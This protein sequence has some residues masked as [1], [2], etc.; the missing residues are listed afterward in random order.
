MALQPSTTYP[1]QVEVGA[2]GYP[3]GKAQDELVAGDGT[4]TPLERDLVNDI[5]G[6]QQALLVAGNVFPSGT[7]DA[8]GASDYLT[9]LQTLF[10][11]ADLKTQRIL[12]AQ[13]WPER[14]AVTSIAAA[15]NGNKPMAFL[16]AGSVK[17]L[18]AF[19]ENGPSTHAYTSNDG[20]MWTQRANLALA[21]G[22]SCV[23]AGV[24][25]GNPGLLA[26]EDLAPN[27]WKSLD[28]A[29]WTSLAFPIATNPGALMYSTRLGLWVVASG[30]GGGAIYTSP[31]TVSWTTQTLP[32]GW[33]GKVAN[34]I[35]DTGTRLIVSTSTNYDK[36]LT[37]PDG[38][39]W[40]EHSVGV[41][42]Q[43]TGLAWGALEQ[44]VM[45]VNGAGAVYT[46][47]NAGSTWTSAVPTGAHGLK[48][49]AVNG[50]VWVGPTPS[51]NFGGLS[52][53]SDQGATW[54]TICVG[55]HSTSMQGYSRILLADGRFV[56]SRSSASV[57]EFALSARAQ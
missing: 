28:G 1:G 54:Q 45:L 47:Q 44:V 15:L 17:R 48:D 19:D 9:A 25:G 22:I 32:G 10:G 38:V 30:A 8:V 52:W 13:N 3:Y 29:A 57:L 24:I 35:V 40:T 23:A 21:H 5:W 4:G 6:F 42:T 39:T 11:N 33:A 18:V 12:Q 49:L 50:S 7:P 16:D 36:V 55:D 46:S 43:W 26:G 20:T 27:L 34:R 37:S 53:S 31:D 14:G 56:L 41:S 2:T 51:G